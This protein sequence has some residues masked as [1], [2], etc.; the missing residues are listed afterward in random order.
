MYSFAIPLESA[1]VPLCYGPILSCMFLSYD[2]PPSLLAPYLSPYQL[3]CRPAGCLGVAA[4]PAGS[5]CTAHGRLPSDEGRCEHT[6]WVQGCHAGSA[7]AGRA[8]EEASGS[9]VFCEL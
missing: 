6:K 4:E 3:W 9:R 8:G 7:T 2:L 5:S 1:T